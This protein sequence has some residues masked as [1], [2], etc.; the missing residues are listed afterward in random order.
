MELASAARFDA[1]AHPNSDTHGYTD[2]GVDTIAHHGEHNPIV[3]L[4]GTV[5][6]NGEPV[7]QG[8]V[9]VRVGD[10]ER[11]TRIPVTNGMF[12]CASDEGC[13]LAGP[14]NYTYAE[15]LVTFHL[16]CEQA[17][18]TYRFPLLRAPCFVENTELQFAQRQW[19]L[20]DSRPGP[21]CLLGERVFGILPNDLTGSKEA[22][23][24]LVGAVGFAVGA[25]VLAFLFTTIPS[26]DPTMRTLVV[27]I[28]VGCAGLSLVYFRQYRKQKERA[29]LEAEQAVEAEG[30]V[31]R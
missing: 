8:E 30:N 20:R 12:D 7:A 29:R 26:Y 13:L 22:M 6:L 11:P 1:D 31:D 15:A 18:L 24:D 25:A 2:T 4:E 17:D 21:L 9:S 10:W 16:N 23:S 14:L 27:L 3:H 28:A 19:T 5:L